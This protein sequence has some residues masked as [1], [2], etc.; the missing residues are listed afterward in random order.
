MNVYGIILTQR[1]R[2][3]PINSQAHLVVI[4]KIICGLITMHILLT[5]LAIYYR[6]RTNYI[7]LSNSL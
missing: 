1:L 7:Y 6:Q 3:E 5:V 4:T 2:E